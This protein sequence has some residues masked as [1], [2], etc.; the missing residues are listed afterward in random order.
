[1]TGFGKA[2]LEYGNKKIVVEVKSLNSKQADVSTR[3]A[4]LYRE[5][6]IE[7]RNLLSQRLE[8]GK[9]DLSLY[10]DNAAKDATAQ[11]N[12][13]MLEAYHQQIEAAAQQLGIAAPQNWF[14]LLL[15]LPDVLKTE[16]PELDDAEW[17]AVAQGINAAIDQL[18]QFRIQEG[19]ALQ[20]VF[21]AKIHNIQTLLA[22]IDPFEKERVSKIKVR[23]E[24]NLL[25]LADKV[26][27]DKNRLEQEL[28][29][30]R[31]RSWASSHR[32]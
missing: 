11:I 10:F 13:P 30:R 20:A 25:A 14:D 18:Q 31:A 1:M 6:D 12:V 16:T 15:R 29:S 19:R 24:E 32:K 2:T 8:R 9:I 28:K 4:P 7:I 3:I 17:E 23:L 5:K 27:Y 21:E 26:D 22:Q